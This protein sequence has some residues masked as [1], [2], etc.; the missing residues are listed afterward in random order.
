MVKIL[1][2]SLS[3]VR[4]MD[5]GALLAECG[6]KRRERI[7]R[8][9]AEGER[10][11][12]LGAGYLETLVLRE[13][14]EG[15]QLY[16]DERGKPH[17]RLREDSPYFAEGLYYSLSHSG[18]HIVCALADA[19]IGVDIQEPKGLTEGLQKRILTENE[20][21][22]GLFRLPEAWFKLWCVK[23]AYMKLTG[24]GL[25]L[26]FDRIE[27]AFD[28]AQ[29]KDAD[30]ALSASGRE[31]KQSMEALDSVYTLSDTGVIRDAKGE[32]KSA[33]FYAAQF[34]NGYCMA[35]AIYRP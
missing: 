29:R 1:H 35:T 33:G 11:R 2:V 27:V 6:Q 9:K 31:W 25:S 17:I 34:A 22:S 18:E 23:E 4:N 30:A 10:L 15:A 13:A 7:A 21:R 5:E 26:A 24:E 14:G 32:Y 20:R 8:M 28:A 16:A 12:L 19:E 3:Q